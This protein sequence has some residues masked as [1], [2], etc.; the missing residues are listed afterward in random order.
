MHR[1]I[2]V[3]EANQRDRMSHETA[4]GQ[5]ETERGFRKKIVN[6]IATMYTCKVT[7]H[8]FAK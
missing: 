7:V 5:E 1:R 3:S 4:A 2:I 6:I 8:C